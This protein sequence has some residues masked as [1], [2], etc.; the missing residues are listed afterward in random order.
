VFLFLLQQSVVIFTGYLDSQVGIQGVPCRSLTEPPAPGPQKIPKIVH[1]MWK[2]S[3]LSSFPKTPSYEKWK[4]IYNVTVWT[5]ATI[6]KLIES[7]YPWLYPIY[8]AYPYNIQRADVARL[9]VVHRYGGIYA[10]LDAFPLAESLDP[11][12]DSDL[13]IFATYDGRAL[14]NHFFMAPQGSEILFHFLENLHKHDVFLPSLPYLKVFISTGPIFITRELKNITS[15]KEYDIVI[16]SE[17]DNKYVRHSDGQSWHG[18]DAIL[19]NFI[20]DNPQWTLLC[21][22]CLVVIIFFVK[23]GFCCSSTKS[24]ETMV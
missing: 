11:F 20:A 8:Q 7:E 5:D 15:K 12:L 9:A 14:S 6:E 16:L 23:K 10:D 24:M 4:A 18:I 21:P 1:Q 17:T 3:N 19:L 2:E 22:L 13:T